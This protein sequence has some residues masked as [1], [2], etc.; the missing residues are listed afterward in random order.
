MEIV[1]L[2]KLYF[3]CNQAEVIIFTTDIN[4]NGFESSTK[5]KYKYTALLWPC[6]GNEPLLVK[7][8]T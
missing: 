6:W 2:L 7:D 4:K 1:I 8:G 5:W 3:I